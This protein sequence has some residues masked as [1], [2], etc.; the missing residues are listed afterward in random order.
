[1]D[2]GGIDGTTGCLPMDHFHL[3]R[4]CGDGTAESAPRA[5][6]VHGIFGPL[7]DPVTVHGG[8]GLAP[9]SVRLES[10]IE[11]EYASIDETRHDSRRHRWGYPRYPIRLRVECF[12]GHVDPLAD[13]CIIRSHVN[14]G[15][16]DGRSLH[17][18]DYYV[19]RKGSKQERLLACSWGG[20]L[21]SL[22]TASIHA[23][24]HC[25]THGYYYSH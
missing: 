22:S 8:R 13:H 2:V 14:M 1:M 15:C 17:I 24:E 10:T 25:F 6:T 5:R 4:R 11:G 23:S 21:L 20:S 12:Q 3:G 16:R 19:L 9:E 18:F 7:V